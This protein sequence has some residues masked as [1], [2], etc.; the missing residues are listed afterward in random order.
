MTSIKIFTFNPFQENT[1][2]LFDETNQC[3]IVDPGNCNRAE[4][5]ELISFIEDNGL[6]VISILNTHCH[7]DHVLGNARLSEYFKV[8]VIIPTAEE[9]VFRSVKLYAPNYGF[10]EYREADNIEYF[11]NSEYG[12]GN[13]KLKIL[14]VPGHTPGHV[15]LL[16]EGQN[17]CIGGD[18]LFDGSIGRTDLPGGDFD[19][20]ISSIKNVLFNLKDETIV[21][22]GHGLSTTIGKEKQ[23]NP[24]VG[25]HLN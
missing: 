12:F 17:F 6:Q 10:P 24:F 7:I 20:L 5:N 14:E 25:I 1:Y 13:T 22:T 15:A 4:D 2:I 9:E 19:T 21:H 8:P 18:V 16:H 3:V 23:S 11:Q